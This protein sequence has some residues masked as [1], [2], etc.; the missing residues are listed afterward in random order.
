MVCM[1]SLKK[2]AKISSRGGGIGVDLSR[3][4][5]KGSRVGSTQAQASG[6]LPYMRILDNECL[7]VSQGRRKGSFATYLQ[8]WH[9]EI[10]TFLAVRLPNASE[11]IKCGNIFT[12]LWN[13]ELFMERVRKNEMYS[14]FCPSKVDLVDVYGKEFNERYLDAEKKKLYTK[15]IPAREIYEACCLSRQKSGM[16][17]MFNK[18]SI[19][20]KN[21]QK[22]IGPIRCSNLCG[23]IVEYT[24]DK[25]IAVCNLTSVALP[26]FVKDGRFDFKH[27]GEIVETCVENCD[28]IIDINLYPVHDTERANVNQRP[29]GIGVQGLS[30][31]YQMMRYSWESKE[32]KQL[33]ISIF[34]TMYY[35]FLKRTHELSL[36]YGS[37]PRFAGSPASKG[38]LQYHMWGVEPDTSVISREQWTDIEG[39]I[40]TGMRNSMGIALMPTAS[41]SQI[42]GNTESIEVVSYNAYLR[43]TLAG[44]F[45]QTNKNLYRELKAIGKWNDM[46]IEQIIKDRGS[47]KNLDIPKELKDIYKTVWNYPK[48]M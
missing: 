12:A 1:I 41:T 35:H 21:P 22:N 37:Y 23:E 17:Y 2:I 8:P 36:V 18:D 45:Y 43:G 38:I 34:S 4:R 11:E 28:R 19:N 3:I 15:Q 25:N 39:K 47:V 32:A 30:D 27:L 46:T 9:P 7:Q 10:M 33:N 20:E 5:A 48:D 26:K 14:L 13:N 31:V 24:D 42:L 16:P 40:K 29:I 44:T 6:I